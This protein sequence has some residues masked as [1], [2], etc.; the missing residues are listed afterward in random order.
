MR[1]DGRIRLVLWMIHA[2]AIGV[3]VLTTV[4]SINRPFTGDEI[5]FVTQARQGVLIHGAP[6][7]PLNETLREPVADDV[8][9]GAF[10]GLWHPP[11]YIYVLA[12]AASLGPADGW[13]RLVGLICLGLSLAMMWRLSRDALGPDVP[14]AVVALPLAF[15]VFSPIVMQGSLFLDIDNTVLL[16]LTLACVH[17]FTRPGDRLQPRRL[18]ALTGL[19]LLLMCVKLT[20]LPMLFASFALYA[21]CDDQ[22]RRGLAALLL[23]FGIALGLFA[24]L[25]LAYCAALALPPGWMFDLGF[26]GRRD[27]YATR[28]TLAA[29]LRS[30]YWNGVWMS[31]VLAVCLVVVVID[32]WRHFLRD[33]WIAPPDLWMVL[34]LVL[35]VAYVPVGAMIG[36]YTMP[37]A[38][39][40]GAVVG[41]RVARGWTTWT[42]PS[43]LWI[44]LGLCALAPLAVWGPMALVRGLSSE[45]N[46]LMDGKVLTAVA[47][48]AIVSLIA[49]L[50]TRTS[51]SA[52]RIGVAGLSV[53]L[54][55][56]LIAPVYTMRWSA[57]ADNSPLRAGPPSGRASLTQ[58]LHRLVPSGQLV[59]ATK[60]IGYYSGRRYADLELWAQRRPDEIVTMSQRADVWGLVDSRVFPLALPSIIAALDVERTLDIGQFRVYVLRHP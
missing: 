40:A 4:R 30:A 49:W 45:S 42:V 28:H 29:V 24:V 16:L 55:L 2:A 44:G 20:T 60:E 31:P 47:T 15:A 36:K 26:G 48:V 17:Q 59:F 38:L 52:D 22:P 33:R 5:E 50:W 10:F 43:P 19:L 14:R 27:L 7:I 1:L 56:A 53:A 23:A 32:R 21:V 34:S 51:V 25:Y 11:L 12:G 37:A 6:K 35:Y 13:L 46:R 58:E 18:V 54:S 3:C 57:N 41:L 8:R 39:M 9:Y